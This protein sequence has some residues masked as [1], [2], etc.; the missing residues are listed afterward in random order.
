MERELKCVICRW[1]LP[2][3]SI[4]QI[5]LWPV[6][7]GH[8]ID[9]GAEQRFAAE[10]GQD[11][12]GEFVRHLARAGFVHGCPDS[13]CRSPARWRRRGPGSGRTASRRA[14]ARRSARRCSRT[15]G[16]W[17]TPAGRTS[18]TSK[19]R[20]PLGGVLRCAVAAALALRRRRRRL[21]KSD[22]CCGTE[23]GYM[24]LGT[25]LN[26]PDAVHVVPQRLVERRP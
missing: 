24:V 14:P 18:P 7:S 1:F 11:I 21:R 20:R 4:T 10:Q 15:P 3:G 2:S 26:S 13:A 25:I 22:G 8:E 23:S 16:S 9:V 12:G 17:P 19:A 5:S 6:R